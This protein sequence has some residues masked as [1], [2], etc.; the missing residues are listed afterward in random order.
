MYCHGDGSSLATSP[1]PPPAFLML[2]I[3]IFLWEFFITH[4]TKA[5]HI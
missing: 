3:D 1:I 5:I 4:V 2:I